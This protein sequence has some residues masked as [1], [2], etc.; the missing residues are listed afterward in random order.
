MTFPV[1]YCRTNK[2]AIQLWQIEVDGDR[3]RTTTGQTDG[4]KTTSEWTVAK[5]KNVGR[6]NATT[7]VQQA[8]AEAQSKLQKKLDAGYKQDIT[9]VDEQAF[10][11][12]ML[13][14]KFE[15]YEG[16]IAYPV[17]CQPKL[18]GIRCIA[19]KEGLFSRNGKPF[20]PWPSIMNALAPAWE[21]D[22]TLIFDGEFY[23]HD[24]KDDFNTI[25]SM[26]KKTKPKQEDI[27]KVSQYLQYHIYDFPSMASDTFAG[28]ILGI[29]RTFCDYN[30][31]YT[32]GPIRLVPT[33]LVG[34]REE[35]DSFYERMIADG[36]EGQMVRANAAY[37]FKRTRSLLKRKD[38]LEDEFVILGVTEGEGNK[39][40]WA[41]SMQFKT[42]EG[43][44][45]NS[46]VKGSREYLKDLWEK[47]AELVGKTATVKFFKPTPDGIPRFP[48]VIKID[49][50]S[51]EGKA[52]A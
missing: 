40:G 16:E 28:R 38:F 47:R 13:A 27:D 36:Y 35:L 43:K 3:Y 6:A 18:D 44:D 32:R 22:P 8:L 9:K 48:Y 52:A 33:T 4:E 15:D 23:N 41:A 42:K 5:P 51:Y 12:P 25:V 19:R 21:K 26:V 39:T 45:F 37:E 31:I 50:E 34:S 17:H 20:Y 2:G 49:R 10:L 46:N 7:G 14:H 1:L 30:V 11:E 24:Y 29:M